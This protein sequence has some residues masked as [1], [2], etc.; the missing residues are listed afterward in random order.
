MHI[1]AVS[2]TSSPD[3]RRA[4]RKTTEWQATC[5][6][7]RAV[8]AGAVLDVSPHGAFFAVI[9]SAEVERLRKIIEVKDKVSLEVERNGIG[10]STREGV[11][12]WVGY[13]STHR[14]MGFGV[15]FFSSTS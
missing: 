11:I 1:A 2:P 7:R 4:P 9:D 3:Q 5:R 13:S 8:V 14:Q 10:E 15:E 6:T 12:R